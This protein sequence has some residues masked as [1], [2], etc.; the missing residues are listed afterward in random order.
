M[1]RHHLM[2]NLA[3]VTS[4]HALNL[5]QKNTVNRHIVLNSRPIGMPTAANFNLEESIL[6]MPSVALNT[7]M[8]GAKVS[9]VETSW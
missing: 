4:E 7:V 3:S 8:V 1:L 5:P 6:P 2:K 9:I